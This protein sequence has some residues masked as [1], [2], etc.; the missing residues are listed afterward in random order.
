MKRDSMDPEFLYVGEDIDFI[1]ETLNMRGTKM[2]Y[3]YTERGADTLG[4]ITF[5]LKV[6]Y[7]DLPHPKKPLRRIEI[8]APIKQAVHEIRDGIF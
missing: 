4:H 6:I 5:K 7:I 3:K 1:I 2:F 8:D